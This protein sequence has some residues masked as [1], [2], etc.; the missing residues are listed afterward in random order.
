MS[1]SPNN[2]A[3]VPVFPSTVSWFDC[4]DDETRREYPVLYALQ[5]LT[6]CIRLLGSFGYIRD[7]SVTWRQRAHGGY[8]YDR[9]V[10]SVN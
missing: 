8:G 3:G 2:Q 10:E 5:S 4:G 7:G 1:T 6:T 9:I